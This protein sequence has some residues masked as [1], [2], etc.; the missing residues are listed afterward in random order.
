MSLLLSNALLVDMDPPRV[1]AGSLRLD[2]GRIAAR[3]AALDAKS[4]DEVID[5]GGA[6]VLPGLVNGH[7]HLYSALAVGMPPPPRIPRDFPEILRF[8]WWRLDRALD[9]A[10]IAASARIGALEAARCG[11]TTLIDHHASPRCIAGSLD[12][13]ETALDEVGVRGVLCYETTDRHGRGGREAGLAENRRYLRRCAERRGGR[14]A[15]LVGAHASFTLDDESL[16][17]LAALADEFRTGVHIH[18][19]E[20]PC[21]ER[22]AVQHRGRPLVPRLAEHGILRPVSILAHG[23]HLDAEAVAAVLEA[24]CAVAHNARSNMNNAVG[25]APT[26]M[27]A[28]S[29]MLGTDGIGADMFAEARAA[30]FASRHHRAGLSPADV[31]RMLAAAARR[32]SE[33][34]GVTLGRLQPECAADVVVTDYVPAT[35]LSGENV[36]GHVLFGL[37]AGHVRHVLVD[38][39][40]VLRDREAVGLDAVAARREARGVAGDLWGRMSKISLE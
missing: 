12:V 4:D 20:D 31:L 27:L 10:S 16:T 32:A 3:A 26:G 1:E 30:W 24:G 21:D 15:A 25:Y 33:Y 6:V 37:D 28:G 7:T 17:Q 8:V 2:G 35:P 29:M 34:L 38:G 22:D 39:R 14:F 11:T 19:A 18:V 36:A 23:T 9:A 5:C 40:W 13:I